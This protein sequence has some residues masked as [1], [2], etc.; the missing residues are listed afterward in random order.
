MN[1]FKT[2]LRILYGHMVVR[3]NYFAIKHSTT[4]E[5]RLSCNSELGTCFTGS[6]TA[7]R[8]PLP[9]KY[10][11]SC[12]TFPSCPVFM[13]VHWWELAA[14]VGRRVC[15]SHEHRGRMRCHLMFRQWNMRLKWPRS[16]LRAWRSVTL[17][18]Y[19]NPHLNS[20]E[21]QI[22]LCIKP[23]RLWVSLLL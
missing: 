15:M 14:T 21:W 3:Y 20:W 22:N 1:Y 2:I 8:D 23:L 12:P 16:L 18:S 10:L 7:V 11:I 13:S 5:E 19:L 17:E 6:G 4:H 9:T